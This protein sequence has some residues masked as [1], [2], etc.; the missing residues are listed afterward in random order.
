MRKKFNLSIFPACEN[1]IDNIY[2]IE[3]LCFKT[4]WSR[5]SFYD[6]IVRNDKAYY[7]SAFFDEVQVGYAGVW[8]I[9]DEAHITN[10]AVH[11]DYRRKGIGSALLEGIIDVAKRNF[12]RGMTLEVRAGN[13]AAIQIYKQYGFYE[14]GVRKKYYTDNNEDALIM[15]KTDF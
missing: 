3:K 1:D 9:L 12:V 5:G 10:I 13:E 14:T 7:L 8:I 4:P 6:E 11:P 15:W 2:S